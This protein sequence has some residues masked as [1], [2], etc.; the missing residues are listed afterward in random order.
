MPCEYDDIKR[1]FFEPVMNKTHLLFISSFHKFPKNSL[2]WNAMLKN[3]FNN[4]VFY[5]LHANWQACNT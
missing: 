2:N 5:H 3:V 4:C 1:H